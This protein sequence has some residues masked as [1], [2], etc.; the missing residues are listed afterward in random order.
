MGEDCPKDAKGKMH[1]IYPDPTNARFRSHGEQGGTIQ[2]GPFSF[3][4]GGY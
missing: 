1:T 3:L 4:E 2:V